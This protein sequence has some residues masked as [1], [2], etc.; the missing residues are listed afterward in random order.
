M[1]HAV[2]QD[3]LA[4]LE[5]N[6]RT[7]SRLV[8][9]QV[10]LRVAHEHLLRP[11][12]LTK[13]HR[14]RPEDP[15]R[16][17][18]QCRWLVAREQEVPNF[19]ASVLV[20][21]EKGFSREGTFNAHNNHHWAEEN[22]HQMFERGYQQRFSVNV[23]AGIVGDNLLGP[24]ILPA[25]LNGENYLVFLREVLPELLEDVPVALENRHWF[26]HDGC[27]A[28]NYRP[29]RAHLDQRYPGRWIGRGGPVQWPPRSPDLTPLDFF[30]W[31][32]MEAHVYATPVESAEDLVA[33]IVAAGEAVR[34]DP[35][36]FVRV[37][38]AWLRRVQKCIEQNGL[39][40]EHLL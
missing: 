12:K 39:Q 25:R 9:D 15:P 28:H 37:R 13:V 7:N 19:R 38:E 4:R 36:V 30:L 23:W 18:D 29:V 40:F 20:S 3:V 8:A 17:L 10:V 11:R 31:G 32:A 22:P 24:Y 16:W 14:L 1:R 5:T 26:Q 27:P 34:Q 6:P 21:D 35:G 2:E 33:R